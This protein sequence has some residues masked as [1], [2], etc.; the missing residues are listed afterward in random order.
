[1]AWRCGTL[2][3]V[4]QLLLVGLRVAR[5]VCCVPGPRARAPGPQTRFQRSSLPNRLDRERSDK[6]EKRRKTSDS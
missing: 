3:E 6:E 2:L 1:M 5:D 4:Q